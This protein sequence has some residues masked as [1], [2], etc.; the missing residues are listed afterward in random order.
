MVTSRRFLA[1]FGVCLTSLFMAASSA[2]GQVTTATLYGVVQDSS[3]AVLPGVSHVQL[4]HC[5]EAYARIRGWFGATSGTHA[6]AR[7]RSEPDPATP[8]VPAA[9][10][11]GELER[12]GAHGALLEDA[13][14]RGTW[15][16]QVI[17]E[18]LSA[19]PYD[20]LQAIPA[21]GSVSELVRRWHFASL[22][23]SYAAIRLLN[24]AGGVALRAAIARRKS[25]ASG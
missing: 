22:R 9:R 8:P 16:I 2:H 10:A 17:Q 4:S 21:V 24:R 3:K 12:L 18:K 15:E 1:S 5:P 20:V 14:E 19:R 25:A 11:L 23:A 6:V 7:E 13:L